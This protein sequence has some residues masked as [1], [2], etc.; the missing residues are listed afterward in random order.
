MTLVI[1]HFKQTER[2][3]AAFIA[4]QPG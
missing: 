4:G 1:Q 2:H 3:L